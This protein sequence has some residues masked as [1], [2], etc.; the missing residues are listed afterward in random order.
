MRK[1][2]YLVHGIQEETY[3][4]FEKR[5]LQAS[6]ELAKDENLIKIKV[7]VTKVKPP[8]FSIIPF[9]KKKVAAI[10][11]EKDAKTSIPELESLT[12]YSGRYLVDEAIPVGYQKDWPD[13]QFTPGICLLTLFKQRVDISRALFLERWHQGHTPLSLKIHPLWNYNRNAIV[14][15]L[16]PKSDPWD[17]IVEEQFQNRSDLLNPLKFFGN[18]LVMPYRMWQVY[19]DVRSFLDYSSVEPYYAHEIHVK[20]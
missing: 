18:P 1:E 16:D 6:G 8:L 2:I 3:A 19:V 20:S 5:I 12:G 15:Q 17:G 10:S 4:E 14:E 11:V 13:S 7:S 9:Q